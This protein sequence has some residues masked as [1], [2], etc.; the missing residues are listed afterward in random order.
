NGSYVRSS[1]AAGPAPGEEEYLVAA[2]GP[3]WPRRL[4]NTVLLLFPLAL[5]LAW[6]GFL[7]D[8]SERDLQEALAEADRLDPNWRLEEIEANRLVIPDHQN[9]ALQVSKVRGLLP[10]MW[11]DRHL[12]NLAPEFQLKPQEIAAVR[13]ALG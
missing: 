4:R 10:E 2:V 13:N 3:V 12:E 1:P 11:A 5:L 9:S 8:A 7:L 6:Y